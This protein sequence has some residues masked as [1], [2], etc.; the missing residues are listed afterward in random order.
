MSQVPRGGIAVSRYTLSL[1]ALLPLAEKFFRYLDPKKQGVVDL[2]QLVD[3][4]TK[5]SGAS[6]GIA[7]FMP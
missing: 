1:P 6:L 3:V 5:V 4:I 2:L 7:Q